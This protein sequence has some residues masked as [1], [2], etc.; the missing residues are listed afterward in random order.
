MSGE[1]G[2]VE[3]HL[4]DGG[5][6]LVAGRVDDVLEALVHASGNEAD[7]EAAIRDEAEAQGLSCSTSGAGRAT[8]LV[9][10]RP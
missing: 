9:V 7:L 5:H 8:I 1:N 6:L 2:P 3:V 10:G 4:P